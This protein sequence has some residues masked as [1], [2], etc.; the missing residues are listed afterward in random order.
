M[1]SKSAEL[2]QAGREIRMGIASW[3]TSLGITTSALSIASILEQY[4]LFKA[5]ELMRFLIDAYQSVF[6]TPF[7]NLFAA[8][9]IH[10]WP[11]AIDL[12]VMYLVI[13]GLTLRSA[14]AIGRHGVIAAE[15]GFQTWIERM[16]QDLDLRT[17]LG[18]IKNSLEFQKNANIVPK[19]SSIE[20]VEPAPGKLRGLFIS[21]ELVIKNPTV[22]A[23]K[24][25]SRWLRS[26]S[27]FFFLWPW[28]L[29]KLFSVPKLCHELGPGKI[30]LGA[31]HR[32]SS[33]G[34]FAVIADTR[35]IFAFQIFILLAFTV[36]V[37]AVGQQ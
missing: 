27:W 33:G 30:L 3:S 28:T 20:E 26:F 2:K 6:H 36:F 35:R 8:L 37:F 12:F 25:V 22:Q 32:P 29:Q 5:R 13:G 1:N 19:G 24:A 23:F 17:E 15:T 16:I 7:A 21:E 34:G 31:S 10:L 18:L 9:G 14:S 4:D 11:P